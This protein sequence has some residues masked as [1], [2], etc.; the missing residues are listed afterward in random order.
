MTAAS[1]RLE[2][3]EI[4]EAGWFAAD[5]FP[6]T[7]AQDQHRTPAHRLVCGDRRRRQQ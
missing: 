6:Q 1:S 5:A 2:E 4:A 7:A 3:A